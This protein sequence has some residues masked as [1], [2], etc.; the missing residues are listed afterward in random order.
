MNRQH[1]DGV[2]VIIQPGPFIVEYRFAGTALHPVDECPQTRRLARLERACLLDDEPR[3]PE[4]VAVSSVKDADLDLL[5]LR[6]EPV[7][8][9]CD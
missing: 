1:T 9:R 2:F 4:A 8:E 6:H 5:R 7:D 3:A